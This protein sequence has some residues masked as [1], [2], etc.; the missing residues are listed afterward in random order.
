MNK[1][2]SYLRPYDI[3]NTLFERYKVKPSLLSKCIDVPKK[4]VEQW[5]RGKTPTYKEIDKVISFF[6]DLE[7]TGIE[8]SKLKDLADLQ[9]EIED[10]SIF[11]L[12]YKLSRFIEA[13]QYKRNQNIGFSSFIDSNQS[14]K[15]QI[16]KLSSTLNEF[17]Y[18]AHEKDE[19]PCSDKEVDSCSDKEALIRGVKRTNLRKSEKILIL[20][21]LRGY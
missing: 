20:K 21:I 16:D 17:Y 3:L 1:D 4:N 19:I 9:K 6:E 8:I 5:L 13:L 15:R 11:N 18:Y 10:E 12:R 7:A 14:I 2:Y